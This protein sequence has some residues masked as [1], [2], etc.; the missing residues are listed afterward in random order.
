MGV[1]AA[2]RAEILCAKG[3][4]VTTPAED[5]TRGRPPSRGEPGFLSRTIP[6]IADIR[7]LDGSE[8]VR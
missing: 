2:A 1:T 4:V 5:N 8:V 6:A 3:L 7:L